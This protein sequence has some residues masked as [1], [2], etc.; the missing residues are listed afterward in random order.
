MIDVCFVHDSLAVYHIY[1]PLM[2]FTHSQTKMLDVSGL[3]AGTV[4]TDSQA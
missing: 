3:L 1:E 4:A 2:S